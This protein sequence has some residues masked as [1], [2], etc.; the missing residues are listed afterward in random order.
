MQNVCVNRSGMFGVNVNLTNGVNVNIRVYTSGNTSVLVNGFK[1]DHDC[2]SIIKNLFGK[3][4][5][6][7]ING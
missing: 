6:L 5:I 3:V 4:P 2:K 7:F 1:G